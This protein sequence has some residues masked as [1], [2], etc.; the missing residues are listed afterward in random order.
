MY[1]AMYILE[2]YMYVNVSFYDVNFV[3]ADTS[4]RMADIT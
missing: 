3:V 4:L 1:S 2:L